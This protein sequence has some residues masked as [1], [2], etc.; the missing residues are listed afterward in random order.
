MK[1]PFP[2][3]AISVAF[4][5][6]SMEPWLHEG[7]TPQNSTPLPIPSVVDPPK[8]WL[9]IL[10]NEDLLDLNAVVFTLAILS[11]ITVM[12]LPRVLRPLMPE[13]S[14]LDSDILSSSFV[15]CYWLF[16]NR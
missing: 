8:D 2:L 7:E 3:I 6:F 10:A 11:P 16:V 5:V 15:F 14:A 12:E 13:K 4:E 1:K 9:K